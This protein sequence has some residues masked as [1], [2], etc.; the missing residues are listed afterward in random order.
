MNQKHLVS[1]T[2]NHCIW[3]VLSNTTAQAIKTLVHFN[4]LDD[5]HLSTAKFCEAFNNAIDVC[6]SSSA[7]DTGYKCAIKKNFLDESLE[8]LD[9]AGAFLKSLVFLPTDAKLAMSQ[10]RRLPKEMPF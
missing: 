3:Q 4:Q 8:R 5:S 1:L 6:N 7:N 9:E 10:T 2:N